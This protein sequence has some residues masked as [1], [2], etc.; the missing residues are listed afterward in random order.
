MNRLASVFWIS[1]LLLASAAHSQPLPLSG[2]VVVNSTLS[3]EQV[4]PDIAADAAD[5]FQIVWYTQLGDPAHWDTRIRRLS[6]AGALGT[7][8]L[9]SQ[10][11]TGDQRA[12]AVDA[13]DG[14]DWVAIWS[15]DHAA[16]TVDRPF[17]RWT[18][19]GA[20]PS[21]AAAWPCGR[22][23]PVSTSCLAWTCRAMTSWRSPSA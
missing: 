13:S 12:P 6:S 11:T 20:A 7:D 15:S 17:G 18:T 22:N 4:G 10:S 14:G 2:D 23:R 9:L 16:A 5:T 1:T 3:G 8:S 21:A 19:S